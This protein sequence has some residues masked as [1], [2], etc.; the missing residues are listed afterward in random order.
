MCDM[1]HSR[2]CHGVLY[3]YYIDTCISWRI[4]ICTMIHD[5]CMNFMAYVMA[6]WYA[7]WRINM[8]TALTCIDICTMAHGV[9]MSWRINTGHGVS[10]RVMV[11]QYGWWRMSMRT[12][13]T[14]LA[15]CTRPMVYECHGVRHGV[16]IF[17][18]YWHVCVV[19]YWHLYNN[20]WHMYEFHGVCHGVLICVMAY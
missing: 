20:S 1:T 18:L 10:I 4:D 12:V 17:V 3:A 19:A 16:L 11:Y 8:R 2:V 6:C 15:T 13:L 7:S 9:C 14:R 5:S